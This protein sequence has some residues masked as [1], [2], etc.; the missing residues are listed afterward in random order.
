MLP[1]GAGVRA[2]ARGLAQGPQQL[3]S[4]LSRRQEQYYEQRLQAALQVRP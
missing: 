3:Q 4:Y 1:V 2:S